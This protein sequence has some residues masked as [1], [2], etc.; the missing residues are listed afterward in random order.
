M[1]FMER[2]VMQPTQSNLWEEERESA[3]LG[4]LQQAGQDASQDADSF[5]LSDTESSECSSSSLPSS[6]E[7]S[8]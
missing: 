4:N 1:A 8:P 3:L 7:S 2:N 5:P 6:P